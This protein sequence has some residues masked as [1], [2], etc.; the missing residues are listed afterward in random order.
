MQICAECGDP[1]EPQRKH[2]RFCRDTCR[3]RW[4]KRNAR[5][6]AEPSAASR[7]A[8]LDLALLVGAYQAGKITR[9]QFAAAA[10]RLISTRFVSV[11]EAL[12][13]LGTLAWEGIDRAGVAPDREHEDA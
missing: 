2:A 4:N 10:V 7:A 13:A 9:G 6:P 8:A 3:V 12:I 11:N 1:F 5:G